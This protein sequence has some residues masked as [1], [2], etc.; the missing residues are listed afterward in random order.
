MPLNSLHSSSS[1]TV[2]TKGSPSLPEL[3]P[4]IPHHSDQTHTL[5]NPQG[6]LMMSTINASLLKKQ[7]LPIVCVWDDT[8]DT[9]VTLQFVRVLWWEGIMK[10]NSLQKPYFIIKQIKIFSIFP[11]FVLSISRHWLIQTSCRQG[12]SIKDD[13]SLATILDENPR[14]YSRDYS[15]AS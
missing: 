15:W 12:Y 11:C 3:H 14:I 4:S 6:R 10:E 8:R 5:Y 2:L 1:L 13:V 9:V 7:K